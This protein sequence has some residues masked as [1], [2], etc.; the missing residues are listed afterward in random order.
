VLLNFL[1]RQPL[2]QFYL[3]FSLFVPPTMILRFFT[4]AP[5][6]TLGYAHVGLD[7]ENL[8]LGSE[9]NAPNVEELV[10]DWSTRNIFMIFWLSRS[11]SRRR[12]RRIV[13]PSPLAATLAASLLRSASTL[14]NIH[15]NLRGVC[16]FR[17]T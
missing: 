6:I 10:L 14:E 7:V 11:S 4:I 16:P 12:K 15:L 2:R 9:Q 13:C 3:L 1:E 5:A 17:S 8:T